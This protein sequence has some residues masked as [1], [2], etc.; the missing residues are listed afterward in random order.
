LTIANTYS[1]SALIVLLKQKDRKAWEYLYEKYAGALYGLIRQVMGD[2]KFNE[3][4]LQQVFVTICDNISQ[5]DPSKSSLFTWMINITRRA[6]INNLNL[7]D[8]D[9]KQHYSD[10]GSLTEN[11]GLGG[12]ITRLKKEDTQLIHLS[13]FKGYSDEDIAQHLNI[14]AEIVKIKIRNALLQLRTLL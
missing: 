13:Y 4:T 14:P 10:T 7:I 2:T 5:Y 9:N 3:E 1:D 8:Q 11:N 12:L 6:A